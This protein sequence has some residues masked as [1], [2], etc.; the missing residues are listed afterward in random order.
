MPHTVS[1]VLGIVT[2]LLVGTAV[3]VLYGYLPSAAVAGLTATGLGFLAGLAF[4]AACG[5]YI[6]EGTDWRRGKRRDGN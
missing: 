4:V 5:A 1:A 2:A 3:G 6:V